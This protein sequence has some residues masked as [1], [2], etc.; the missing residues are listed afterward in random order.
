MQTTITTKMT[1]RQRQRAT[2]TVLLG[3]VVVSASCATTPPPPAPNTQQGAQDL[4]SGGVDSNVTTDAA[5][6]YEVVGS[7][8]GYKTFS[9]VLDQ[10]SVTVLG[11]VTRQL[12][13]DFVKDSP[14]IPWSMWE[15]KVDDPL[16]ADIP[17]TLVLVDL[18]RSAV[19]AE[20]VGVPAIEDGLS[21]LFALH[22]GDTEKQLIH[23]EF[24]KTYY[25]VTVLEKTPEGYMDA[26]GL[27][28]AIPSLNP[29]LE[30]IQRDNRTG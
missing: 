28:H 21:G 3:L 24:G 14:Q 17:E 16:G 2:I 11:H 4:T 20:D 9:E 18:D 1:P 27:L 19:A 25:A 5:P 15:L 30:E 23:P 7:V 26:L 10:S 12:G 29:L 22:S 8:L 13:T 6:T